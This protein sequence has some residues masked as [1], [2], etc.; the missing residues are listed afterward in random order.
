MKGV[1]NM[2]LDVIR[3][4]YIIVLMAVLVLFMLAF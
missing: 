3:Y 4:A 2:K 1:A